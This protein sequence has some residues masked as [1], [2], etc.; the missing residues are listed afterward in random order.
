MKTRSIK[1]HYIWLM[2]C[3]LI[4]VFS[5]SSCSSMMTMK[6]Q[7]KGI[8]K[9]MANRNFDKAIKQIEGAKE[10]HYAEKDRVLYYLDLGMLYHYTGEYEKSN[11][12]LTQ[13]EYAI[14]DLFTKSVSKAAASILLND[15]ALDYFGEDYE[16]IYLNVFKALNYI[17]LNKWDDAIVEIKRIDIKLNMLEDKYRDMAKEYNKSDESDI[18]I[19]SGTTNFYSSALAR[20]LSM[21]LYRAENNYDAAR[22]D[23]NKIV[24]AFNNEANIYNF[25]MPNLDRATTWSN[26]ARV[27]FLCFTGKGVDKVAKTLYIHTER[28]TLVIVPTKEDEDFKEEITDIAVIN[29]PGIP[30]NLHFKFQ[31]PFMKTLGSRV[32]EVRIKLT[33][34]GT[35]DKPCEKIESLQK[36][37]VETF[38]VKKPIIY[39]KTIARTVGKGLGAKVAKDEINK[40]VDDPLAG[41][42][43]GI[44]VDI[45][46]DATENADLRVSHFFPAYAYVSEAEVAPGTYQVEIQYYGEN[47]NLLFVDNKGEVE[48]KAQGFNFF[49]SFYFN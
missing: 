4:L 23:K 10:K 47:G 12:L 15:N 29:S 7:Y 20:Y 33:A 3:L 27:N 32:T 22:I 6:A 36:V 8:D 44:A 38:K 24:D 43:L 45:G 21:L 13:A 49:E 34:G 11:A 26:K 37:A 48:L 35:V 16:D 25:N 46:V 18:A 39:L 28:G 31:L 5:V 40:G 42:L 41:L 9:M 1:R 30:D 2:S 14:E 19:K 17:H